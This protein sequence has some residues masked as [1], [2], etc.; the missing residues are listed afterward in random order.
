VSEIDRQRERGR[1]SDC[2]NKKIKNKQTKKNKPSL[3]RRL[4]NKN[5]NKTNNNNKPNKLK[6][7]EINS[8]ILKST[9]K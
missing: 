5:N 2:A 9:N 7:C 1:K 4:S 3:K 8:S 6:R